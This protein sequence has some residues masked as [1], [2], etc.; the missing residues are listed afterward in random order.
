MLEES[1]FSN[2]RADYF[3]LLFQ[4]AVLLLVSVTSWAFV[5]DGL[6]LTRRTQVLSPL[7]NLPFLSSSLAFVPIYFWSRRHP[8]TQI[9]LFGIVTITAPYLPY[10]LIGFSWLLNGSLK[11][12][13]GDLVGC[14]VGHLLWFLRDV[15]SREMLGARGFWSDAPE[16]LWAVNCT[17]FRKRRLIRWMQETSIWRYLMSTMLW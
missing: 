6:F 13:M 14:L 16:S 7:V 10:A 12:A 2:R 11:L 8:S 17:Y 1:S 9:S 3:W 15:W 5:C 4:S